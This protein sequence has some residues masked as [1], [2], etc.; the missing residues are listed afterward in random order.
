MCLL[1]LLVC[2]VGT[3]VVIGTD[4]HMIVALALSHLPAAD[5]HHRG[6]QKGNRFVSAQNLLL[7]QLT[8]EM[9]LYYHL[10]TVKFQS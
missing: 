6:S 9:M 10:L 7:Q 5:E 1:I 4:P 8:T 2:V 3:S